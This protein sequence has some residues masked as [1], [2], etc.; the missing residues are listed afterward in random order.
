MIFPP[1][2]LPRFLGR[3]SLNIIVKVFVGRLSSAMDKLISSNQPAFLKGGLLVDR[4]I[5]VNELV[6]LDKKS[7]KYCLI[8]KV[9]F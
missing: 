3:V 5:V 8:F 4:V 2:I 9:I 6:D 1:F 7:N